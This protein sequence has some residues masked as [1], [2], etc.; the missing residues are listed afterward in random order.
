MEI[1]LGVLSVS[2]KALIML[3]LIGTLAAQLR[4]ETIAEMAW[5]SF[6]LL[7]PVT[8]ILWISSHY[9]LIPYALA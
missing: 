7:A 6:A 8:L 3:G 1:L 5:F 4:R 9:P 2:L